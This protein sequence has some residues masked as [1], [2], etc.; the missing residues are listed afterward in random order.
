MDKDQI[1]IEAWKQTIAVQMHFNDLELRIRAFG[2]TAIAAIL[3][4][5][6]LNAE[7]ANQWVL[8]AALVI[9][10][11]FFL[12]ELLWYHPLLKAAVE[13]GEAIEKIGP[14]YSELQIQEK[15]KDSNGKTIDVD[16]KDASVLSL[17]RR[18]TFA[19]SSNILGMH[20]TLKMVGYYLIVW[21][22]LWVIFFA[23]RTS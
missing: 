6:G 23:A 7:N 10:P 22:G 1:T 14:T 2:L 17:T 20:S 21:V 4:L 16:V 8:A 18:I 15:G 11:A 9:W 3:G 13:H 12:M 5:A 19:S